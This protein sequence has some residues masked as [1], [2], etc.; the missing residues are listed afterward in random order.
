MKHYKHD[1]T[2]CFVNCP[3]VDYAQLLK[4]SIVSR[5]LA[6]FRGF[7]EVNS[8][9]HCFCMVLKLLRYSAT[10]ET[11]YS[12]HNMRNQQTKVMFHI[13]TRIYGSSIPICRAEHEQYY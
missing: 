11:V 4:T 2:L 7:T 9:V 8:L 3:T 12:D 10:G 13:V 6:Y 1:E 5:I